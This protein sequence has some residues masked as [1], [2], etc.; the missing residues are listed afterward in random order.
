[1]QLEDIKAR[2][3]ATLD[4]LIAERRRG[5]GERDRGPSRRRAQPRPVSGG[6][7]HPVWPR[8]V[9]T[10]GPKP[11]DDEAFAVFAS[12]LVKL[13]ALLI[14]AGLVGAAVIGWRLG[15]WLA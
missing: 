2:Q 11:V 12:D 6:L 15:W 14:G 3:R 1:M 4:T 9:E 13:A 7:L 5:L 10:G 8:A